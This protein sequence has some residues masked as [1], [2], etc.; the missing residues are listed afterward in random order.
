MNPAR[1]ATRSEWRSGVMSEHRWAP[2]RDGRVSGRSG[3]LPVVSGSLRAYLKPIH[4][5]HREGAAAREKI[6][7]DLAADLGVCVPPVLLV[8]RRDGWPVRELPMCVSLSLHRTHAPVLERHLAELASHRAAWARALVFD[9][10]LG[11]DH[12]QAPNYFVGH[13]GDAARGEVVFIDF[14]G[15]M[16]NRFFTGAWPKHA[17]V[18]PPST[19]P[20]ALARA[21]TRADLD[22]A[23]ERVLALSPDAIRAVVERVPPAFLSPAEASAVAAGLLER[24]SRLGDA[25]G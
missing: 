23:V 6:A 24:R 25:L 14:T 10:W 7:A 17:G 9:S 19:F 20:A 1:G 5:R 22:D 18:V 15:A 12:R 13:D 4:D 3:A 21:C 11:V 2:T 8:N 16:G